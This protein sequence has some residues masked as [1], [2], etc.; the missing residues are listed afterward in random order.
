MYRPTLSVNV[1]QMVASSS[2]WMNSSKEVLWYIRID[3]ILFRCFV[4]SWVNF[5]IVF[6]ITTISSRTCSTIVIIFHAS[7]LFV[8]LLLLFCG[9]YLFSF[10]S[11]I[12]CCFFCMGKLPIFSSYNSR[13]RQ[14]QFKVPTKATYLVLSVICVAKWINTYTTNKR[15][16]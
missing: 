16:L 15:T 5:D 4:F 2:A 3:L 9:C 6:K 8:L 1:Q 14:F 13:Y 7:K 12:V 10:F 11:F